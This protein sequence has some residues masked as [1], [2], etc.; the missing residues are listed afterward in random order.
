VPDDP[1]F[2]PQASLNRMAG[3]YRGYYPAWNDKTYK[4]LIEIFELDPGARI[5]G[6]S[7]GMQRQAEVLLAIAASPQVLLLDESFDGLD[8]LKRSLVKRILLELIAERGI[9]AIISS[10]NLHELEDLCDHIGLINDKKLVFDCSLVDMRQSRSKYR[11]AFDSAVDQASFAGME[12]KRLNLQGR[13][14]TFIAEAGPDEIKQKL[15]PLSPIL[16][17]AVPMTIEEIFLDEM[18][19]R[20]YDLSDLF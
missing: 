10:H 9:S 4:K 6:F 13:V 11:A 16:F 2:L 15:A 18:E 14:V 1:Y 8:P 19:V 17:E 5:G 7:K 12:L 3:F 20:D